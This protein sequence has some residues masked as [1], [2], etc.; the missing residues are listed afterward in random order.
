MFVYNGQEYF[1]TYKEAAQFI[2]CSYQTIW[3]YADT[4]QPDSRKI[5]LTQIKW[6]TFI[7]KS[8]II[9]FRDEIRPTLK[10]GGRY[11]RPPGAKDKKPREMQTLS[12]P[13]YWLFGI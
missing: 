12:K 8:E 1:S 7:S 2:G 5:R 4:R 13:N 10:Y 11:G 3:R 9:R 6:K